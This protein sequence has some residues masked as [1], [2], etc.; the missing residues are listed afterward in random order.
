MQGASAPFRMRVPAGTAPHC[1]AEGKRSGAG[2]APQTP[3]VLWVGVF[4]RW[5]KGYGCPPGAGLCPQCGHCESQ[6]SPIPKKPGFGQALSQEG[7]HLGF[8]KGSRTLGTFLCPSPPSCRTLGISCSYFTTAP[9]LLW[10]RFWLLPFPKPHGRHIQPLWHQSKETSWGGPSSSW[11]PRAWQSRGRVPWH[12]Q[13][14]RC[15][16][17]LGN[18]SSLRLDSQNCLLLGRGSLCACERQL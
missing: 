2:D 1:K 18:P 13:W 12:P 3:L 11:S 6:G 4:W 7:S 10:V 9:L 17:E 5:I 14:L 16:P 15:R 8:L